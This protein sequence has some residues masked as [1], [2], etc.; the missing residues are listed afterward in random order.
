ML[1]D[2]L[3]QGEAIHLRH[4]SIQQHQRERF[5]ALMGRL[6]SLQRRGGVLDGDWPHLPL[7]QRFGE[8]EAIG[9]VIVH[10]QHGQPA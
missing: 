8:D 7:R 6:Q 9:G 3:G 2:A 5:A 4:V 1:A 10:H